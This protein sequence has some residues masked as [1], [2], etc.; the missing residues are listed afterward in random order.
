ML[1]AL[2]YFWRFG[3][4]FGA[5]DHDEF[6]P[7][8]LA[9][10]DP[11]L[12]TRD[13]FVGW[14]TGGFTIRTPFL[15]VL[16]FAGQVLPL[17]LAVFVL[18]GAVV[19]AL[20]AALVWLAREL[21][22]GTTTAIAAVFAATTLTST[23]TLGGNAILYPL[24]VPEVLAWPLVVA[25]VVLVLRH[26]WVL[27]AALLGLA[28]WFHALAGML[29]ALS[30]GLALLVSPAGPGGP[31][32]RWPLRDRAKRVC[33]LFGVPFALLV[34]PL[35]GLV[36]TGPLEAQAR[37]G[38]PSSFHVMA[39]LR[40]VHHYLPL[41]FPAV[42][43]LQFGL[44]LVA[45]V[46]SL[47]WLHRRGQIRHG[48]FLARWLGVV[49]VLLGVGFVFTELVPILFVAKLQFFKLT[50]LAQVL[51]TTA[52]VMAIS[53]LVQAR[54]ARRIPSPSLRGVHL[55]GAAAAA[56]VVTITLVLIGVGRPAAAFGP[57]S[58]RATALHAVERWARHN[59]DASAL[60]AIPP[61][62]TT[63]RTYARRSAVVTYKSMPFDDAAMHDWL[64]RLLRV[65]PM[66]LPAGGADFGALLDAA[67]HANTA[68]DWQ[69]L[70][71]ELQLDYV[72]LDRTQ[73]RA[74]VPDG[75][76]FE[77]GQ[78]I[79]LALSPTRPDA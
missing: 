12:Y 20:F 54:W 10:L 24:L 29:A 50:V 17:E 14:M 9:L 69:R 66:E 13:W 44:L 59:T 26:Q 45:G 4:I 6:I 78:W 36:G 3:Y 74:P 70:H 67:F 49:G 35:V 30:L 27:A 58:H 72:L 22:A 47:A 16:W 19:L 75:F 8:V 42:R 37:P 18:Y 51:L 7:A 71:A 60:F 15:I 46:A 43:F 53:A 76:V 48:P 57:H 41:S 61:T 31:A 32:G 77:A 38:A 62:N 2:A 25:A 28:A 5:S 21:G 55:T 23:W 39:E 52:I 79:V 40:L 33:V 56:A 64:Q 73:A 63:F 1:L 11:S 65:A 34:L 68:A